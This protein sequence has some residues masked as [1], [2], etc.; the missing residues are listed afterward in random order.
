MINL[1]RY[2]KIDRENTFP[3][4][5]QIAESIITLIQQGILPA[6][7]RIQTSRDLSDKLHVHRK[8]VVTAYNELQEQGWLQSKPRKGIFVSPF[9]QP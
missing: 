7:V 5:L 4:Y 3:V 1:E 6:R 2:I 9:C 8:T